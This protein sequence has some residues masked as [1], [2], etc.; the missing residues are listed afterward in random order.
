MKVTAATTVDPELAA[1]NV[2]QADIEEKNRQEH[3][4]WML[5]DIANTGGVFNPGSP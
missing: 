4:E 2:A 5:R 1:F 3:R